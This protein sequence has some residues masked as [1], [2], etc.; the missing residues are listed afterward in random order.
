MN[1]I[2]IFKSSSR[3]FLN[4]EHYINTW[5][6]EENKTIL[7]HSIIDGSSYSAFGNRQDDKEIFI[8]VLYCDKEKK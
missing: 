4:M 6:E 1:K 5:A 3:D 8:S 2:K 7:Q